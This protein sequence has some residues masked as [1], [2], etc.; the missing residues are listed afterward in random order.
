MPLY[1]GGSKPFSKSIIKSAAKGPLMLTSRKLL[2][3]GTMRSETILVDKIVAVDAMTDSIKITSEGKHKPLYFTA[4]NPFIWTL[5]IRSASRFDLST[6]AL[7]T[8]FT[9]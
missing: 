5:A 1:A 2:F 8:D 9:Y 3:H 4:G 7:P 6:G